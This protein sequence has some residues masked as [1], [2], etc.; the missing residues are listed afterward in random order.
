M[1]EMLAVVVRQASGLSSLQVQE[2]ARRQ[3]LEKEA[4]VISGP[5]NPPEA[6]AEAIFSPTPPREEALFS[7]AGGAMPGPGGFWFNINAELVIYGATEPDAAVRI[8]GQPI[9][10]GPDGTFSFR[11]ALP[12]GQY[13]LPVTAESSGGE[14]R[15]AELWF[16]R[17]TVY[18]GEV[19]AH[20]QDPTLKPP[21]PDH[22][23]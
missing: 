15:A 16:G 4:G 3:V 21:S 13:P 20:P 2:L 14:T 1:G 12:D 11:F 8:G 23:A 6:P 18:Y 10:L 9:R 19:G 22:V 5:A 7:P 17:D